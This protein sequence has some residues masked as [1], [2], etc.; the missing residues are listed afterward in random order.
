[1]GIGDWGLDSES[2]ISDPQSLLLSCRNPA[3]QVRVHLCHSELFF[4]AQMDLLLRIYLLHHIP[5]AFARHGLF[6]CTH[7]ASSFVDGKTTPPK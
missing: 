2:P 4:A 7:G 5:H 3:Q 6:E 1:M